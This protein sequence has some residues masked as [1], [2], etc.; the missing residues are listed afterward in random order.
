MKP[1]PHERNRRGAAAPSR[2]HPAI[3]G[4]AGAAVM[5]LP[6]GPAIGTLQASAAPAAGAGLVTPALG[7]ILLV[8]GLNALFVA[9]L[10]AMEQLRPGHVRAIER[11][12]DQRALQALLADRQRTIAAA[13][14]G[15]QTMRAWMIILS[16]APAPALSGWAASRFGWQ[17][18]WVPLF[19]AYVAITIPVAAANLILGELAPKSYAALHP[20]RVALR[21]NGFLRAFR[22]VFA[23]LSAVLSGVA[24]LITRRFGA[25]A[26]FA[27]NQAEEEIK[28]L[29][30][31]AQETG[32]IEAEE[33]E[34][35]H[36]VFEF[37]DTVAREVMTPRVDMDAAALEEDPEAIIELIQR[38]GHSRIPV[39]ERTGDQIVGIIHAKDLLSARLRGAGPINLR[40]ILRPALFVPENKNLHDLMREM[41]QARAQMAIVQDEFGGTAGLVTIEDIVEELVGDI[42][43]EYDVEQADVAPAGAGWLVAGKTHLDD[44]ND[45]IGSEFASEEFDTVGGFVF[46]LFG[47]QPKAGE[48][49]EHRDYRFRVEETDGRRILRL[50]IEPAS[51]RQG[52][53]A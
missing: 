5:V 31:S 20:H 10:V 43:D 2:Y 53:M 7:G 47:R 23:P 18:G 48:E 4:A 36:S 13:T 27:L 52:S 39:Y 50:L 12:A 38:S 1:D 46:G 24:G 28:V 21:L 14:L 26:S 35:L 6:F 37:S 32:E 29:V 51:D 44:L 30:D 34:L 8:I 33:K 22:V 11:E 19:L 45:A 9:G 16:L 15:S 41:R 25:K 3:L 40:T 17:D 49:L 42:V